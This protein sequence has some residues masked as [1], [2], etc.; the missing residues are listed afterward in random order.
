MAH[1]PW[2]KGRPRVTWTRASTRVRMV[3][4]RI[5]SRNPRRCRRLGVSAPRRCPFGWEV[6][7]FASSLQREAAGR[8]P[9]GGRRA[10]DAT[11]L[12]GAGSDV[13]GADVEVE[14]RG[15]TRPIGTRDGTRVRSK[16]RRPATARPMD[17]GGERRARR[18]ARASGSTV[19]G[20]RTRIATRGVDAETRASASTGAR[21]AVSEPVVERGR[22]TRAAAAR[23]T[24]TLVASKIFQL[25]PNRITDPS[26]SGSRFARHTPRAVLPRGVDAPGVHGVLEHPQLVLRARAI[27]SRPPPPPASVAASARSRLAARRPPGFRHARARRRRRRHVRRVRRVLPPRA[28]PRASR[29]PPRL[30]ASPPPPSRR[31]P[32]PRRSRRRRVRVSRANAAVA[33]PSSPRAAA[34]PDA[35]S[36]SPRAHL[37]GPLAPLRSPSRGGRGRDG[38]VVRVGGQTARHGRHRLRRTSATTRVC[39]RSSPTTDRLSRRR[40]RPRGDAPGVGRVRHRSRRAPRVAER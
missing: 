7:G 18:D 14:A 19:A 15:E 33:D 25:C 39:A 20:D 8:G 10:R 29:A 4:V 40:R 12:P 27:L 9:R 30:P 17:W 6:R 11:P 22:A 1:A 34:P 16:R 26:G 23:R 13:E 3:R 37:A 2:R 38:D 24:Q 35:A 36:S 32:P 5:L 28:P 31:R 21:D